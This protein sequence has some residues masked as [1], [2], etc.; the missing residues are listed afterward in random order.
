MTKNEKLNQLLKIYRISVE[1]D[2]ALVTLEEEFGFRNYI[3]KPEMT[4]T[5][6]EKWWKRQHL[7]DVLYTKLPGKLINVDKI[8]QRCDFRPYN[9]LEDMMTKLEEYNLNIYFE[10]WVLLD[11][12]N[13]CYRAHFFDDVNSYIITPNGRTIYH[14]GRHPAE[15]ALDKDIKEQLKEQ[16]N[17]EIDEIVQTYKDMGCKFAGKGFRINI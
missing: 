8:I 11:K 7:I 17:R 14:M 16:P 10:R 5:D 4:C 15:I 13:L 6:F 9:S 2:E 12:S 1:K 3:W